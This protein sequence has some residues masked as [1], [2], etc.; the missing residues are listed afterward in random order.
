MAFAPSLDGAFLFGEGVHGWRNSRTGR[1]MDDLWFY[2]VAGHAWRNLYPGFDTHNPPTITLNE[3]GF[4]SIDGKPVPIA[5]MVHGYDMT[6]W[7]SDAQRFMSM[8]AP[9][10]YRRKAIPSLPVLLKKEEKRVN[11]RHASP[12]FFDMR[13]GEW[14]RKRTSGPSVGSGYG[15]TLLYLPSL[16]KTFLRGKRAV[17]LYDNRANS[18][19]RV[20][21]GGPRPPFGIDA[22]SCLDPKRNRIYVGGGKYPV[23]KGPNALWIFDIDKRRWVDPKPE[24]SPGSKYYGTNEALLHCDLVN[25]VVVLIRHH[26]PGR[27]VYVYDPNNNAWTQMPGGLPG[28]W[29]SSR[30]FKAASGFYHPRLNAH[31]VFAAGDSRDNG[32]VFVYRLRR[33]SSGP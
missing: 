6:A 25:D 9:G 23:S 8:P 1:Y 7:D 21:P 11:R 10:G 29:P 5:T 28:F 18:W 12:W 26:E 31:F 20:R 32:R 14:D 17:W 4:T 30:G 2:D 19:E 16:K 22:N 24:G 27:G 3:D 33:T 15:N 13:R